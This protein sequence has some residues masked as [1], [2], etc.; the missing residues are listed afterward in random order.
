[1]TQAFAV[2]YLGYRDDRIQMLDELS[3]QMQSMAMIES[4]E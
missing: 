2:Q 3:C 4:Q 1:M